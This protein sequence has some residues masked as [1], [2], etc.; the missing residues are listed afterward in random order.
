MPQ[1]F[2]NLLGDMLAESPLEG[3]VLDLRGSNAGRMNA[4]A[5]VAGQ[6]G[7]TDFGRYRSRQDTRLV[8][9]PRQRTSPHSDTLKELPLVVL[10]DEHS[11]PGIEMLAARLQQEGRATIVGS[12][13]RGDTL[14]TNSHSFRGA[15]LHLAESEFVLPDG[16]SFAGVGVMPDVEL[17]VDW[18]SFTEEDDPVIQRAVEILGAEGDA[19]D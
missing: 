12:R 5:D 15:E 17:E 2:H 4:I 19:A 7:I 9:L 13:T 11:H 18:T 1:R 10:V 3:L 6:F 8:T 14:V 16:T